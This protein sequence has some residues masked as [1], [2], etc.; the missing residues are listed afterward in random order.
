MPLELF[1]HKE[2]E[3]RRKRKQGTDESGSETENYGDE[4]VERSVEEIVRR[5]REKYGDGSA[6]QGSETRFVQTKGT[7]STGL[8]SLD[9]ALGIGGLPIGRIIEIFGP[10]ACGKS[11][12]A[13][14]LASRALQAKIPVF[15]I[16]LEHAL[17]SVFAENTGVDTNSSLF[18]ISQP[19]FG[20]QVFDII[21]SLTSANAGAL[22]IIDSVAAL[23]PKSELDASFLDSVQ[24]GRQAAL[25]SNA[26][27]RIVG[28]VSKSN[29]TI[30]FINQTRSKIGSFYLSEDTPGGKALKFYSSVRI[31]V[32]KTKSIDRKEERI[33]HST[34]I[35]VEKNKF[36][37]PFRECSPVIFYGSG[38]SS[39]LD[40]FEAGIKLG[41]VTK[42]GSWYSFAGEKIGQGAI[43]CLTYLFENK[44]L[45]LRL[46][47]DVISKLPN[48]ELY[49]AE[50]YFDRTLI[51]GSGSGQD[52]HPTTTLEDEV[53]SGQPE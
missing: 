33:G 26:L 11:N 53:L 15:F 48:P 27:R 44:D 34:R 40:V 16:D 51:I 42:L 52:D 46:V 29:T 10:E 23:L 32:I 30:V 12:L 25:M 41:V 18:V 50:N 43:H 20:E 8:V 38:F 21:E 19:D 35:R 4:T 17:D 45:Y 6:F 5:I 47:Q 7:I 28:Q 13:L 2:Y 39:I 9:A 22:A 1:G 24:P 36:A 31:K 49:K 14:K 37:P 3:M